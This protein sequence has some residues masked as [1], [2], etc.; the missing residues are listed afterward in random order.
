MTPST[1]TFSIVIPTYNGAPFIARTIQS[2]LQQTRKAD[3]I[4]ISDDHS[5]DKTLDICLPYQDKIKISINP[6]GPS[7]FV[8][9]W[10]LAIAKAHGNYISI[11][12]QDDILQPTFLQEAA[13]ALAAHPGIKHLFVPCN[14][15]DRDDRIIRE[16][17]Y[18]D[19]QLHIY[20]GQQ[21]VKAYQTIGYPHIHRC[22]GVITHRSIFDKIRYNP[23]A[24]HIADD[25]FFYRAGI[26]TDVLGILKPLAAYRI[27]NESETGHLADAALVKR[28]IDDYS[29]QVKQWKGNDFMDND[30][31]NFFV[32]HL[33]RFKRRYLAYG[34]KQMDIKKIICALK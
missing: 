3:E 7:G 8:N 26:Y 9:A 23:A 18:C 29:F 34:I 17:D 19:G 10:N 20:S 31:Y 30:S 11:L 25:D 13:L 12:H 32:N 2:V 21:Y 16:A 28:L 14:Y 4:I 5:T 15:I 1:T 33:K 6:Q 22:P 27:H 24:G